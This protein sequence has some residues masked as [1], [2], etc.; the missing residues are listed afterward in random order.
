[1]SRTITIATPENITVTY[2]VAGFASR[3]LATLI[4]LLIQAMLLLGA[5]LI[6]N[7]A[8]IIFRGF[9]GMA[10]AIAAFLIMFAYGIIF[11]MLWGGRTPGKRLLGLRVIREGGYPINMVSSTI[12]NVLRFMDFGILPI[13]TAGLILCG[14]P[15]L[16][17]IFFS[18]GYKRIGDWAAGTLVIVEA[19]V[20]P[21]RIQRQA[22]SLS[23]QAS[24]FLPW[25]RNVERMSAEEY[26][27]VRRFTER[28]Q[29]WDIA[30]QSSLGEYLA[31]PLMQKLEI[32]PPV[33]YQI[34]YA[35][36]LEALEY[37]YTEERGLL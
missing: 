37:R 30:V 34:Q 29:D 1:M 14:L 27:I 15:G 10:L 33:T 19:G 3:F 5:A 12:R 31:R 21:F 17:C 28:R 23:P 35:D 32:A 11:E 22:A 7:Q 24:G 25:I 18:P 2:E 4:D 6:F 16:L 26:Q 8:A 20:T 36:L 13:G 9:A